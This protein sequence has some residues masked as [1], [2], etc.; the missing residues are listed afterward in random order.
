MVKRS[1]QGKDITIIKIYAL[2]GGAPRHLQQI[3]TDIKKKLMGIQS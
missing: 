3:L 1:I 2:N